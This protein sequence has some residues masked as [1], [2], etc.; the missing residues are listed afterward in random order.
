MK[1]QTRRGKCYFYFLCQGGEACVPR[2]QAWEWT[3][4]NCWPSHNRRGLSA[5]RVFAPVAARA[6]PAQGRGRGWSR[7]DRRPLSPHQLGRVRTPSAGPSVPLVP[8]DPTQPALTLAKEQ[9]TR[10]QLC[11]LPLNFPLRQCFHLR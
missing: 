5:A 6:E 4:S 2:A 11:I 3:V 8:H 10:L 9:Y 7:P 1:S